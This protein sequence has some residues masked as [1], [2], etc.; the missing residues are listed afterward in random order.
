LFWTVIYP[1]AVDLQQLALAGNAQLGFPVH[2]LLSLL[3]GLTHDEAFFKKSISIFCWPMVPGIRSSFSW[4]SVL[5]SLASRPKTSSPFFKNWIFQ[6]VIWAGWI[7]Y[8]LP[9][10]WIV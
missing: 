10:S 5:A 7:S 2:Q 4:A 8:F 6:L 9:N 1:A 3:F